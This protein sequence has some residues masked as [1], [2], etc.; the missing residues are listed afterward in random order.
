V[1]K[2][3]D[4]EL[5]QFAAE[6]NKDATFVFCGPIQTDISRIKDVPNI[7]LLGQ[8]GREE[9]PAY[10][11]QFDA[12]IIPYRITDYTRNVYPTKLNEYLAMGKSVI[13][14]E[15]PEIEKFNSENG[16]IVRIARTKSEF[17]DSVKE[18]LK[19]PLDEAASSRARAAAEKNSWA[20]RVEEMSALIEGAC[21][22]KAR[23]K[24]V[25][26][27]A[28]LAR[29][30]RKTKKNFVP[31]AVLAALAY[32]LVFHTPLIWMAGEPLQIKDSPA[33]ADL[34]AVLGGGVGESGKAGQNHEER[35]AFAVKL[36]NAG[37]ADRIL[38]SSGYRYVMKEAQ[39]MKALSVSLG[40][41]PEKILLDEEVINTRD[42]I[43]RLGD[44]MR[45][46]GWKSVMIISSPYHMLRVKLLCERYLPFGHVY[47]VPVEN[48]SYYA[49]E[50]GVKFKHIRG[51]LHEY[52]AIAYY[53]LKHYI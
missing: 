41:R 22:E 35:V 16:E 50:G 13:S 36:F 9:L 48:G 10:V 40:I 45:E 29:L 2:W 5:V 19:S 21:A 28:N 31:I 30:Y 43:S 39:V 14:T 3:I 4:F 24:E 7:R 44:L 42:M 27:K 11:R 26:W 18:A 49:K 37:Y 52:L 34:I 51:I 15:L 17:A 1:H 8:K 33:K 25:S 23:Q 53:R 20:T 6:A 46:K 32:L 47:Y 38:Y 12:A